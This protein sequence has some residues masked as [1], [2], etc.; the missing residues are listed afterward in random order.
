MSMTILETVEDGR[1]CGYCGEDIRI[2]LPAHPDDFC[3][4]SNGDSPTP[5]ER[6]LCAPCTTAGNDKDAYQE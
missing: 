4:M 1:A 2:N 5:G 6:G 3:I